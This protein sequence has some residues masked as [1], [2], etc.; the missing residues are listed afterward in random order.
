MTRCIICKKE[1]KDMVKTKIGNICQ[2]CRDNNVTIDENGHV[3][4]REQDV[5]NLVRNK[6]SI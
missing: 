4:L 2:D 6:K 1:K 5:I 3:I